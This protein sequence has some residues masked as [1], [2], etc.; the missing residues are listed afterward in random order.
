MISGDYFGKP[1]KITM[2]ITE[3]NSQTA[4]TSRSKLVIATTLEQQDHATRVWLYSGI[5]WMVVAMMIGT[6][7]A[8][9]LFDPEFLQGVPALAYGRLRP[10]HVNI[11]IFGFMSMGYLG[12]AFYMVP[13]LTQTPLFSESLGALTAWVW[14]FN[15]LGGCLAILLGYSKG[16]EY[17]EIPFP[18]NMIIG[19]LEIAIAGNLFSTVVL[20]REKRIYVSLWYILLAIIPFP[21][22]YTLGNSNSFTGIEDAIVNWFYSHNLFGIWL[23]ALG[24]ATLYYIVPKQVHKPLYSHAVSFL[25]FWTLAAFYPWNGGHHVIWGPVPMWVMSASVTASLAML[26]PTISTMVNFG[27]TALGTWHIFK[28]DISYRFSLLAYFGYI[29]ASIW[30][31]I[32]AIM[33]LNAVV[34]FTNMTIAHVHL[35]FVGFGV[36]GLVAFIYFYIERSLKLKYSQTLAEW[37]F[38]L[39]VMGILGYTISMGVNGWL[40]G[41]QWVAGNSPQGTMLMRY[42]Y[43]VARAI[44]GLILL[45]GQL[46]FVW[47]IFKTINYAPKNSPQSTIQN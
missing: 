38:W 43:H 12:A 8:V 14:N 7:E 21:I 39:T 15:L 33:S 17:E 23:T 35:G 45:I 13:R 36:P 46:L 20:R 44:S 16:K 32:L 31:S 26:V 18:F 47:N 4:K 9:K 19:L 27:G 42:P 10:V 1:Y 2:T 3:A 5:F 37:H 34:H 30:G 6:V 28:K 40:E 29:G 25:G 22:Y 11:G 41:S 24:L